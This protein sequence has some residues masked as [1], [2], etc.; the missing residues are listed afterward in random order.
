M[1]DGGSFDWIDAQLY[2]HQP[3]RVGTIMIFVLSQ[4]PFQWVAMAIH[5]PNVSDSPHDKTR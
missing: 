5:V 3:S 4:T 1:D 2:E